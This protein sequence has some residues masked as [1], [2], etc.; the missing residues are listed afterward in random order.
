MEEEQIHTI[1]FVVDAQAA[2]AA[3]KGEVV[4]QF[5]KKGFEVADEGIL[6]VAL[7]I[8]IAQ[9]EKFEDQ[10]IADFLIGRDGV[11][12]LWLGALGEHGGLVARKGRALV[13]LTVHLALEL[14]HRPAAT[15]SLGLVESE[16]FG[17]AAAP[18]QEDVV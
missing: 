18:D 9:A 8:L 15:Q 6:Q 1:P 7:G 13:E 10:G 16:G 4:A 5:Q 11:A 14:A 17:R 3:D 12:R 2:L